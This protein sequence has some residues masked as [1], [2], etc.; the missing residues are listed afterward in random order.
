[1]KSSSSKDKYA[2]VAQTAF[3]EGDWEMTP[4]EAREQLDFIAQLRID[5]W[6]QTGQ[7]DQFSWG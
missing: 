7:T 4:A 1:M 2:Q 5:T 6:L 3:Y